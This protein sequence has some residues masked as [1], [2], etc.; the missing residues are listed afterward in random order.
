M[1]VSKGNAL[2]SASLALGLA[3]QAQAGDEDPITRC[4]SLATDSDRIACLEAA[5][6]S[7]SGTQNDRR[8]AADPEPK[9]AAPPASDEPPAF[10]PPSRTQTPPPADKQDAARIANGARQA[11]EPEQTLSATVSSAR[12]TPFGK[13][14]ITLDN[15]QTWL[16]TDGSHYKGAVRPGDRIEIARR[17]FGGHKMKVADNPGVVLVRRSD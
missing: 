8:R 16:E 3:L 5:I 9:P 13:L 1:P 14:V 6:R 10:P 2:I 17:F 4:A 11:V 7:Q 12:R 15:G